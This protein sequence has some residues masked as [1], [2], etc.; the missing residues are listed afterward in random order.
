MIKSFRDLHEYCDG[1][2][3]GCF[4][5]IHCKLCD[6]IEEINKKRKAYHL[7]IVPKSWTEDNLFDLE[8]YFNG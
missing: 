4:Q 8:E 7:S 2:N 6:Y 3:V 5:C 1:I